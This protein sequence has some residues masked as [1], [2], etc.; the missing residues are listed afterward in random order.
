MYVGIEG[1]LGAEI[2]AFQR[3]RIPHVGGGYEW[4]VDIMKEG[5]MLIGCFFIF[6]S[7]MCY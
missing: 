5:K 7:L 2:H 6:V 3:A 4:S 1:R